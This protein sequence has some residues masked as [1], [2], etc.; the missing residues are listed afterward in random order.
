MA[1][2]MP[3]CLMVRGL[4]KRIRWPRRALVIGLVRGMA[5]ARDGKRSSTLNVKKR[6]PLAKS[7]P[8]YMPGLMAKRIPTS[9]LV[10]RI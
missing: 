7:C 10:K 6:L 1:K 4:A 8:N 9:M 5:T 3:K 2:G